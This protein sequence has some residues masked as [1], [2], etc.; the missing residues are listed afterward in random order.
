MQPSLE[1]RQLE[2]WA[3]FTQFNPNGV[4]LAL[5]ELGFLLMSLVFVCV[6]PASWA[7]TGSSA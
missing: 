1:K 6:A 5:E 7:R 2:G 4:L 3:L